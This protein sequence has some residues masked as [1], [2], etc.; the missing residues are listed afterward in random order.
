MVLDVTL[1]SKIMADNKTWQMSSL[2]LH[3]I[4]KKFSQG[5]NDNTA[6]LM[7]PYCGISD[8]IQFVLYCTSSSYITNNKHARQMSCPVIREWQN[9]CLTLYHSVLTTKLALWLES[10]H[11]FLNELNWKEKAFS[12]KGWKEKAFSVNL[13]IKNYFSFRNFKAK[14]CVFC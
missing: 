1:I 6:W 7:S 4:V 2:H 14:T 9:P 10:D 13:W 12:L 3:N 5:Y 8:W 11:K